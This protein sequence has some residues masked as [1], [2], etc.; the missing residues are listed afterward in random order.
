MFGLYFWLPKSSINP[1]LVHRVNCEGSICSNWQHSLFWHN[2]LPCIQIPSPHGILDKFSWIFSITTSVH[3]CL[4]LQIG[5]AT[6]HTH[7]P[8]FLF[9]I[10]LPSWLSHSISISILKLL[11]VNNILKLFK[12]GKSYSGILW[13]FIVFRKCMKIVVYGFSVITSPY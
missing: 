13:P 9:L 12:A 10:S 6:H 11:K 8:L 2:S 5:M 3:T 4:R 7:T 1:D